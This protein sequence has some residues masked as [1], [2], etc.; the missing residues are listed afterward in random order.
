[1]IRKPVSK[2]KRIFL[3]ILSVVILA[4]IY[5]WLS[6][7]YR[8][9]HP[10][11]TLMPSIPEMATAFWE[12]C[13]PDPLTGEI[14]FWENIKASGWRYSK[15]ITYSICI[16]I[17]VGILMGCYGTIEGLCIVPLSIAAGIP[18]TAMMVIFIMIVGAGEEM[19]TTLIMFGA[20]PTLTL[21]ICQAVKFDV[22]KDLV[23]KAYTLGA[24]DD[25]V[26]HNVMFRMVLPRIIESVRLQ[27]GPALVYLIAAE[28]KMADVGFGYSIGLDSKKMNMAYAYPEVLVLGLIA[29]GLDFALL[30]FRKWLC[31]WFKD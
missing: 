11:G 3:G 16:S 4:G 10:K 14:I 20:V 2:K 9:E 26:I 19:F 18:P 1:M 13:T 8:I 12:T 22:H 31:P 21:A 28:L 24:S 17:V 23:D 6:H 7:Q 30:H 25:E 29:L 27:I 5:S 15:A